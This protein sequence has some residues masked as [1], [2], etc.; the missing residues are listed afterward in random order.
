[1]QGIEIAYLDV[2]INSLIGAWQALMQSSAAE[3]L[4]KTDYGKKDTFGFDAIAEIAITNKIL[5]FDRHAI[6]IT[7]ELD[8]QAYRRWPTDSDPIRQPLMF[9]SDPIDRSIEM[10]EFLKTISKDAPT[11]KIGN[12]TK[13]CCPEEIWE[14]DFSSPA[15]I[16][17]PTSAITCIRK[18][19]IVFSVIL[20]LITRTLSVATDAGVFLYG[21]KPFTEESNKKVNFN[22]VK[23]KGK[24]LI[25]PGTEELKY[26]SDQC[27]RFVTFLGKKGY[28]ENFDDSKIFTEGLNSHIHYDKPPGPPR[29]LYL[30]EIQPKD[31]PVGFILSNGEKIGEWIHWLSFAKYSLNSNG[32]RALRVF[33]IALERPW[34]KNGMLMSTSIPYSLFYIKN[35]SMYLD[36]SQLRNF[37]R[38]SQ[39]RSMIVVVRFD[40]ERIINILRQRQYREITEC[41]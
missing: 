31:K 5:E 38:P 32:G 3:A 36:I 27:K 17:G 12:L 20:N 30:S 2:S 1:M 29:V 35:E 9:F 34:I 19:K 26:S 37:E 24:R 4:D 25:F 7:E 15:V 10:I 21:L 11:E 28:K 6:L 22:T 39:F 13:N 16:T 33:E 8:D 23:T 14:K 41:F 40:N 18:G